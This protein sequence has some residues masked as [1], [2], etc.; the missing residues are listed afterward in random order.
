MRSL[1]TIDDRMVYQFRRTGKRATSYSALPSSRSLLKI[2]RV[3]PQ[4]SQ[5]CMHLPVGAACGCNAQ[6]NCIGEC[7]PDHQCWPQ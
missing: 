6:G 3:E 4:Q 1:P 5:D 2:S 7:G